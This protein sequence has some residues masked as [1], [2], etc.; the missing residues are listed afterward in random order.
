MID[1]KQE[2]RRWEF[3]DMVSYDISNSVIII[4]TKI[5][6]IKNNLKKW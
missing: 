1:V 4:T 5:K 6:T 2:L 3:K